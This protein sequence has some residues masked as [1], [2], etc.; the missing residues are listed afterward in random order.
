MTDRRGNGP[1]ELVKTNLPW[2]VGI[3]FATGGIYAVM[4]VDI[5]AAG[6]LARKNEQAIIQLQTGVTDIR[7]Q[8]GVIAEKL[9]R[10]QQIQEQ[11]REQQSRAI[12]RV[13]DKLER[14]NTNPR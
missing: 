2:I 7:I 11:F 10:E 6:K 4:Q 3:V 12:E 13:L 5:A 9:R 1:T 8:Q 14:T